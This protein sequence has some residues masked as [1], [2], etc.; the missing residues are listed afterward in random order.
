MFC[1][2]SSLFSNSSNFVL[3]SPSTIVDGLAQS[4]RPDPSGK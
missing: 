2:Q 1:T 3:K 4:A